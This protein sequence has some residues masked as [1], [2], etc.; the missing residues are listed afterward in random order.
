MTTDTQKPS[1]ETLHTEYNAAQMDYMHNDALPWQ[2]GTILVAG[3]FIFWGIL[4]NVPTQKIDIKVLGM[5][6]NF[7]A[8]LLT[9]WI[10]FFHHYRQT[11]LCKLDRMREIEKI[12]GM[13]SHLRWV[14]RN[15]KGPRYKNFGP[16]G[17]NIAIFVYIVTCLGVSL[18]GI[19]KI[20]QWS[21]WLFPPFPI[22]IVTVLWIA[23]QEKRIKDLLD[24]G[25]KK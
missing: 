24:L 25:G 13:D 18:I 8:V 14:Q 10:F 4:I 22:F 9:T 16:S 2:I 20:C 6:S 23:C 5:A 3:T 12:L 7:I 17:H 15:K 19:F 11:M 21:W 1:N